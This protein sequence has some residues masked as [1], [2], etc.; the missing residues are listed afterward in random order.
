M[1]KGKY[2]LLVLVIF[3]CSWTVPQINSSNIK[4]NSIRDI[5]KSLAS[6][7]YYILKE[8]DNSWNGI[9][10]NQAYIKPFLGSCD[11]KNVS[12]CVE[13]TYLALYKVFNK[14]VSYRN[15][16]AVTYWGELALFGRSNNKLK[17]A[18]YEAFFRNFFDKQGGG[19]R[20]NH[21]ETTPLFDCRYDNII[22][23]LSTSQHWRDAAVLTQDG[24]Y[25][26]I[27]LS[28]LLGL[29]VEDIKSKT[30]L[31]FKGF[32]K[33]PFNN[34]IFNL[35]L[36]RSGQGS[37]V[38]SIW[39]NTKI[40]AGSTTYLPTKPKEDKGHII[41]HYYTDRKATVGDDVPEMPSCT[42]V[43]VITTVD[44]RISGLG[45]CK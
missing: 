1:K 43:S 26:R 32:D 17:M 5:D 40:Q 4:F 23:W 6:P 27:N 8:L 20:F 24:Q 34:M 35:T 15:I 37:D 31:G 18:S 42:L 45:T 19:C 29:P 12:N 9:Y 25:I 2:F 30:V 13:Y 38:P 3:L 10:L 22:D 36:W 21:D 7:P 41:V 11:T 44:G 14:D 28:R 39:G 33:D 16:L